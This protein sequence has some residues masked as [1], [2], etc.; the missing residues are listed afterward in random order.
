LIKKLLDRYAYFGKIGRPVMKTDESIDIQF[1]MSLIQILDVDAAKYSN[2]A[3][4][5]FTADY[6]DT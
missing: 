1:G 4:T 6:T 3:D 2:S 5:Q